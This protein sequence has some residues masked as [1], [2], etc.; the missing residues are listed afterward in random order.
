MAESQTSR[1]KPERYRPPAGWVTPKDLLESANDLLGEGGMARVLL[2][3]DPLLRRKVALKVQK[4]ITGA[5]DGRFI[6]EAQIL[7]QLQH[8]GLVPVYQLARTPQGGWFYAM[9]P[10]QGETLTDVLNRL[11]ARDPQTVTRFTTH[12][13]TILFLRVCETVH[14]AHRCGV[15]H[16]DI[17]P[18]NIM[19][20]QFGAVLVMDWGLAKVTGR[21]MGV[22]LPAEV[23]GETITQLPQTEVVIQDGIPDGSS[24]MGDGLAKHD[25]NLGET[26]VLTQSVKSKRLAAIQGGRATAS[27][28]TL[29]VGE[30]RL[31]LSPSAIPS[32]FTQLTSPGLVSVGTP[33]KGL[34]PD[35]TATGATVGS[36]AYMSPEQ[37]QH[38]EDLDHR[39]DIYSLGATLYEILTLN[40]PHS[41]ATLQALLDAKLAGVQHP[42][43][44]A[45][46]RHI[47]DALARI[48]LKCLS[49]DPKDRFES[50]GEILEQLE[51]FLAGTVV[52]KPLRDD[53]FTDAGMPVGWKSRSGDWRVTE[54]GL[55]Q[56]DPDVDAELILTPAISGGVKVQ[57]EARVPPGV[58]GGIGLM[59]AYA[60]RRP[61]AYVFR[62]GSDWQGRST[63]S[64]G[65]AVVATSPVTPQDG[66]WY[67]VTAERQDDV[68][69]L[70]VNGQEVLDYVDEDP[71]EEGNIG[72]C[73]YG[74][75]LE[76]RR[77]QVWV[78]GQA[79]KVS[80]L[81]VPDA[82]R[83]AKDYE[84]ALAYYQRIATDLSQEREGG[85]AAYRA[86]LCEIEMNRL[87]AAQARF[88]AL[89]NTRWAQYGYIGQ[90]A[91]AAKRGDW[92]GEIA[93]LKSA[94]QQTPGEVRQM[95]LSELEQ[96]SWYY[97]DYLAH[98]PA[99][100]AANLAL[101]DVRP[102]GLDE[103]DIPTAIR[104][105]DVAYGQQNWDLVHLLCDHLVARCDLPDVRVNA[106]ASAAQADYW[107]GRTSDAAEKLEQARQER[108]AVP[109]VW[110]IRRLQWLAMLGHY[111]RLPEIIEALIP[112]LSSKVYHAEELWQRCRRVLYAI[113]VLP[114]PSQCERL[115]HKLH[116]QFGRSRRLE[117][118]VQAAHSLWRYTVGDT[119][120]AE[121]L[122]R[123]AMNDYRQAF[124]PL[125]P[126]PLFLAAQT[127]QHRMIDRWVEQFKHRQERP[128]DLPPVVAR[129]I[130]QTEAST[131]STQKVLEPVDWRTRQRVAATLGE[132]AAIEGQHSVA[133]RWF[134]DCLHTLVGSRLFPAPWASQRYFHFTG[135]RIALAAD[136]DVPPALLMD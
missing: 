122:A 89:A 51:D 44:V 16:R 28:Q 105:M 48:A 115:L 87:V 108:E 36:P 12:R 78:S 30:N 128:Y 81:A 75:G 69:R 67:E 10:V 35:L 70:S 27:S 77:V 107:A 24:A 55:G 65:N 123:Q 85:R 80:C 1:T 64:K 91:V 84:N 59:L 61:H 98:Q 19:L 83:E 97:H 68:L 4:D 29:P 74:A 58:Q 50:V 34:M 76:V 32:P 93:I 118:Q 94:I 46:Q 100:Y 42:A 33:D 124:D 39:A 125:L 54:Q 53:S 73:C 8:P 6:C 127:G 72:L 99:A 92:K 23:R 31:V 37:M 95:I 104:V 21:P 38:L 90:A 135:Q 132:L 41:A 120:T 9:R 7:A 5:T 14:Y 96:R 86:G 45:P 57:V 134:D 60:I 2:G 133:V 47:P 130:Q 11:R 13:L 52:W 126:V 56:M 106:L 129:L 101:I 18:G 79:Q 113:L 103:L 66:V 110:E 40:R 131:E 82:L 25:E 102:G 88:E 111:V 116:G 22:P 62:F 112:Q 43:S 49:A 136:P 26:T 17:K 109:I 121:S 71:L 63:L 114:D 20:D 3:T 117:A 119:A 15:I